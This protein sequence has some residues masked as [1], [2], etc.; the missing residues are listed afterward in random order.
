MFRACQK[1][2]YVSCCIASFQNAILFLK[3]LSFTLRN[4]PKFKKK[5]YPSGVPCSKGI[6]GTVT[7]ISFFSA[8]TGKK[9]ERSRKENGSIVMEII[10]YKPV[11]NGR[12]R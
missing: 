8:K 2:S 3:C 12:L 11:G 6:S 9:I 5:L 4:D 7:G 10:S 1:V